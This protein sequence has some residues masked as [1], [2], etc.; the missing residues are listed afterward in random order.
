MGCGG[1]VRGCLVGDR[2]EIGNNTDIIDAILD[3]D[4]QVG[5]N[6]VVERNSVLGYGVKIGRFSR[7]LP[8]YRIWPGRSISGITVIPREAA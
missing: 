5:P 4:V 8:G 1:T 6:C 7:V 2:V 3:D